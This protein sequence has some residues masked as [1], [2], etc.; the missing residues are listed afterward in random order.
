M[1]RGLVKLLIIALVAVIT[2]IG[3]FIWFGGKLV[4]LEYED[5]PQRELEKL[6]VP[7]GE[8][9]RLSFSGHLQV[10]ASSPWTWWAMKLFP[11]HLMVDA[12]VDSCKVTL[13]VDT[14]AGLTVL[15]P[16]AAVAAQASLIKEGPE[17]IHWNQ[18]I[19]TQLGWVPK[20]EIAGLVAY[21]VPVLVLRK[22]P[23][24]KLLGISVY[25][26]DG[27]LGMSLMEGLAVTLDWR[28]GA[29][30]LRREP[31]LLKAPSAQ[32]RIFEQKL[33]GFKVL[34]PMVDGFLDGAGPYMTIIDTGM[35]YT[36]VLISDELL[37]VLGWQGRE[38]IPVQLLRMGEI[39]LK[40]I[41][42]VPAHKHEARGSKLSGPVMLIGSGLFQAQGFRRLTL[43]FLAGKL[44]AER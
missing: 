24:L 42:A 2:L 3:L 1:R 41:I 17:I 13:L 12:K 19:P 44:Y 15:S 20:I 21:N 43:D 29:V 18:R 9:P 14:G 25:Q 27:F 39:E 26:V 23:T 37:Q 16:Q 22:Q 6:W 35:S 10:E 34:S 31:F 40:G 5:F 8:A 11:G 28:T 4:A 7:R 38:K 32:L 30:T 36:E 33:H